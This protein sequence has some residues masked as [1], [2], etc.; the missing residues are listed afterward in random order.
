MATYCGECTYLKVNG[1]KES[2]QFWCDGKQDWVFANREKG[3]GYCKDYNR[4]TSEIDNAIDYS[5]EY[6]SDTTAESCASRCFITTTLCNILSM[7]DN[8]DYLDILRKFREEYLK[9]NDPLILVK[10]D[11]IGP[12]I[13][14][15]LSN[16]SGKFNMAYILFNNYI[17]PT[18]KSI[19]NGDNDIA[20]A[21]YTEMTSKLI[22][23]YQID[24]IINVYIDDIDMTQAG[25]GRL[26]KKMAKA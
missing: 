24:D 3:N 16:D 6:N 5:R 20:I 1:E 11:V 9:E 2:G 23:Y 8:N 22:E 19:K 18:V 12:K 15:M 17:V 7:D 14:R 13:S 25:H 4:S 26:V 10:Y 21:I